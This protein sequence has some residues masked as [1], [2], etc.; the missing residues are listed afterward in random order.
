MFLTVEDLK[1]LTG[2]HRKAGMIAWLKDRRY[3]FEIGADGWPKVL[4]AFVQAKLGGVPNK[5][6]PQVIL[7]NS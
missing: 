1:D 4:K 3:P 6:E 2:C 7:A 5:R